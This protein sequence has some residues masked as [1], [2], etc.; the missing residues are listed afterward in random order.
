MKKTGILIITLITTGLTLGPVASST[1]IEIRSEL[2]QTNSEIPVVENPKQPLYGEF[3]FELEEDLSIGREDDIN[4]IFD[5]VHNILIDGQGQIYV[6]DSKSKRIQVFD[7]D[8]QYLMTVGRAGQGP[9]EFLYCRIMEVSPNGDIYVRGQYQRVEVFLKDGNYKTSFILNFTLENI[10]FNSEGIPFG[11]IQYAEEETAFQ[12]E[13]VKLTP[14]FQ[15]EESYFKAPYTYITS[16]A[17][18]VGLGYENGLLMTKHSRGFIVGDSTEYIIYLLNEKG[19][20]VLK[21]KKD[22]SPKKLPADIRKKFKNF[23]LPDHQPFFYRFHSDNL[24]R[25]YAEKEN[26]QFTE[27]ITTADVF[28]SD[29]HYLYQIKIPYRTHIID[30]GYLYCVEMNEDLGLLLVKRYLISN[31]SSMKIKIE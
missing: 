30:K 14:S 4:Y 6:A 18:T 20:K 28:G 2:L 27:E 1:F 9:G 8:G 31:W 13:F 25:I 5:A 17:I 16:G 26:P 10:K 3:E 12:R 23:S 15:I 24:G 7:K 22:E 11:L 29:G 19:E 21:I